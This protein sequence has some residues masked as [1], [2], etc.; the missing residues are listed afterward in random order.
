MLAVTSIALPIR[1]PVRNNSSG[2]GRPFKT[3]N[4]FEDLLHGQAEIID[5]DFEDVRESIKNAHAGDYL[6]MFGYLL[7]KV[8]V[9]YYA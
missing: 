8:Y 4:T 6:P 7:K 2:K 5:A 9:D 3:L 1:V